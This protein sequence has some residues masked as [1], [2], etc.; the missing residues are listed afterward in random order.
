MRILGIDPGFGRT[1]YGIIDVI[2]NRHVAVLY[3]CIETKPK[4]QTSVRLKEIYV[5][6][7]DMIAQYQP[8]VVA[9]EELFFHR[10]VTTAI[11]AAEA[12]GVAVLA[13]EMAGV[14]QA[15][16]TPLQ[17]KQAVVGFGRADKQQ[18][19]QMVKTLLGLREIPKPDDAADALA[20]ALAHAQAQ[21]YEARVRASIAAISREPR[22]KP[23][24]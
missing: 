3:G 18:V 11:A 9:I 21:P 10:N 4:S 16:Y 2:G 24:L 6:I 1:G 20:I 12:R 23:P 17:V 15:E 14:E 8:Q 5:S 7:A 13:A 22:R 19:Q